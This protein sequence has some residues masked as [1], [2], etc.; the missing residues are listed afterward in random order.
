MGAA[1]QSPTPETLAGLWIRSLIVW[2]DG[3][4]DATTHVWWLQGPGFYADLRQPIGAPRFRGVQ[5]LADVTPLQLEWMATQEAFAGELRFDGDAFDW[6]RGI[7]LQPRGPHGDRG[8]L[9]FEDEVMIERG[10]Y[11]DYI[12]HWHRHSAPSVRSVAARLSSDDGR[13][14]YLI[15]VDDVFMYARGRESPLPPNTTLSECVRASGS[16]EAATK[17]LDFEVALGRVDAGDWIIERSSLPFRHAQR[18]EP[19]AIGDHALS[20]NDTDLHAGLR[21]RRWSIDA[22]SGSIADLLAND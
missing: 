19:R 3:R 1:T 10:V 9:W 13:R 21:E 11:V 17:L 8:R 16:H 22:L 4:R 14:G 7:D 18:L 2:P 5:R 15:R 12:E 20:V 6:E